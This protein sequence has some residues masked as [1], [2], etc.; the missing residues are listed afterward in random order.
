MTWFGSV[1]T[2]SEGQSALEDQWSNFHFSYPQTWLLFRFI[3]SSC[4]GDLAGSG[5]GAPRRTCLGYP[6][7]WAQWAKTMGCDSWS[8]H[9][10]ADFPPASYLNIPCSWAGP[11]NWFLA[12]EQV[13]KRF[14]AFLDLASN[15]IHHPPPHLSPSHMTL[16]L[17][18]DHVDKPNVWGAGGTAP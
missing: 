4:R 6:C 12:M 10:V 7:H 15:V 8:T 18:S 11:P 13:Q 9:S 5:P 3:L 16:R 2:G 1:S 17:N 14:M